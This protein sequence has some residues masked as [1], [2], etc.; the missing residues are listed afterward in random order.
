M[1]KELKRVALG[2]ETDLARLVEEV[3][4]DR[5]PRVIEREGEALAVLVAPD[6]YRADA[7]AR[8]QRTR[9]FLSFAGA[10]S[11]LDADELIASI[12]RAREEGSRP[13]DRP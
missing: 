13:A 9:A 12:H 10:W 2:P 7:A 8:A 3:H 4:A 11:D 1:A 5:V 6:D